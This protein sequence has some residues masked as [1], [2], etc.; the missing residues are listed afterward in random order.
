MLWLSI[1]P[2]DPEMILNPRSPLAFAQGIRSIFPLVAAGAAAII[3][4]VKIIQR[5]PRTFG[6]F[7]PLGLT[8]A[9]GLVG[10]AASLKSP[11]GSEALWWAMLYLS[12]PLV[13]WGVVWDTHALDHVSRLVNGTW[14]IVILAAITLFVVAG[15]YLDLVDRFKNPMQFLECRS[16]RW[17]DLTEW[18]LRETGVGRYAAIAGIIAISGL[19]QRRWRPI[20]LAVLL[21]CLPLLLYTGARGSLLGFAAGASLILI[22]YLMYAGKKALFVGV[23]VT[24]ILVPILWS[25]GAPQVFLERCITRGA[26]VLSTCCWHPNSMRGRLSPRLVPSR[27]AMR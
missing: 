6:L 13:L 8:T 12:V 20:C 3:I 7:G 25:T 4:G 2:G 23:L 14:I 21:T 22:I 18:K 26:L 11:D 15:L 17:L 10:L 5:N 16:T 1:D 9:Y 19:W 24:L 27:W